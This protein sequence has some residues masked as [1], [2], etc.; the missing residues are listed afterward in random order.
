MPFALNAHFASHQP[1][2]FSV[3]GTAWKIVALQTSYVPF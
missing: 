1:C 2:R 3:V